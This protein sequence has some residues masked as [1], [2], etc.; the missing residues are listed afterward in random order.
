MA[1]KKGYTTLETALGIETEVALIPES[2]GKSEHVT[3]KGRIY[4]MNET[5]HIPRYDML[6]PEIK[7]MGSGFFIYRAWLQIYNKEGESRKV[8]GDASFIVGE[9]IKTKKAKNN[10]TG[11]YYDKT[12]DDNADYIE[13][14][15]TK[16]LGRAL[17]FAG[18]GNVFGSSIASAED[19]I[20]YKDKERL[21]QESTESIEQ[22]KERARIEQEKAEQE[23]QSREKALSSISKLWSFC[24]SKQKERKEALKAH[25]ITTQKEIPTLS[26]DALRKLYTDLMELS[27]V[28]KEEAQQKTLQT[29]KSKILELAG[30]A[31]TEE[32]KVLREGLLEVLT[33]VK[34]YKN[35]DLHNSI[36]SLLFAHYSEETSENSMLIT[37]FEESKDQ[38]FI[39][40][41]SELIQ[42]C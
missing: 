40:D 30:N 15:Q 10:K 27:K 37:S 4:E 36:K 28:I 6:E 41:L 18:F 5:N 17:A 33:A 35:E 12:W 25:E 29:V 22:A 23:K 32:G 24:K 26:L 20:E 8:F 19:I 3:V 7:E 9:R 21:L 14:A 16:A 38:G 42:E 34:S 31:T 11:E 2:G 13:K 1:A 39:A